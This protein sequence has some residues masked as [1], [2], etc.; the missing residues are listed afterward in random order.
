MKIIIGKEFAFGLKY[1]LLTLSYRVNK[2]IL[3]FVS[4]EYTPSLL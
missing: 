3:R 1:N 2:L 4:F